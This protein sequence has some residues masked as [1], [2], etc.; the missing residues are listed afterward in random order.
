MEKKE[1]NGGGKKAPSVSSSD[2][3]VLTGMSDKILSEN[4]SVLSQLKELNLGF[5]E[6]PIADEFLQRLRREGTRGGMA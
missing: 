4:K 3:Y 1:V 6:S 5:Q 2:T